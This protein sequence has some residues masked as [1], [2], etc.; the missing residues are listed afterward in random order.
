MK[1]ERLTSR[2]DGTI[3]AVIVMASGEEVE[4]NFST[5]QRGGIT[6]A[7]PDRPIFD[8]EDLDAADVRAVI[9]AILAFDAVSVHPPE[10]GE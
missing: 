9:A 10:R 7:S 1:I 3:A 2:P 5:A 6:V 8:R 4:V